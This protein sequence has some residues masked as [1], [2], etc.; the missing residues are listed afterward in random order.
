VH[1]EYG[2][3]L[4][5]DSIT[6]SYS[7]DILHYRIYAPYNTAHRV[8]VRVF[9]DDTVTVGPTWTHS[10]EVLEMS[11]RIVPMGVGYVQ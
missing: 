9:S 8:S 4:C 10:Y 11:V 3:S 7:T 5:G 1:D 2:D 6:Y